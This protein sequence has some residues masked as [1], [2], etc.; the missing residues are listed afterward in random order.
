MGKTVRGIDISCHNRIEDE[1]KITDVQFVIIR[2]GYGNNNIDNRFMEYTQK[3]MYKVPL[4]YYWFSYALDKKMA[5][6]EA[7]FLCDIMDNI[8]YPENLPLF[9]DFEYD[10]VTYFTKQKNRNPTKAEVL[11]IT[12]AFLNK[13]EDLGY[14]AG[15]YTNKDFKQRY[16][17]DLAKKY[18]LWY[19]LY[20]NVTP[21]CLI[22]QQTNNG[23]IQGIKGAVDINYMD[24]DNINNSFLIAKDAYVG[25]ADGWRGYFD[26]WIYVSNGHVKK[27]CWFCT[28]NGQWY[29]F[30]SEGFMLSDQL[31]KEGEKLYYLMPDGHMA[32]TNEHGELK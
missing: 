32:R 21:A 20:D 15:I 19:A 30:D 3:F 2:A 18:P 23:N 9:F 29:R 13:C 6:N 11:E 10:S 12:E 14:K 1:T 24:I 26:K 31:Y 28:V 8:N 27:D 22:H 17:E 7:V 16:Y 5:E 25:K 4:G